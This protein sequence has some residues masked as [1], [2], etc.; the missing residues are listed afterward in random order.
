MN[1]LLLWTIS[2]QNTAKESVPVLQDSAQIDEIV[3]RVLSFGIL[4]GGMETKIQMDRVR[5]NPP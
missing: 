4:T 3:I 2:K 5:Q 1:P